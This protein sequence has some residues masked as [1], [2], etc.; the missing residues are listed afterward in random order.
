MGEIFENSTTID[1][2]EAGIGVYYT[3]IVRW[4]FI[5]LAL[6]ILLRSIFSLLRTKNPSEVWGYWHFATNGG[7][8]DASQGSMSI[9]ITHWENVIGRAKSC[10]LEMDDAECQ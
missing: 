8:T 3:A 6:F 5:F 10:D 4:V 1:L 7:L 2:A 9:P